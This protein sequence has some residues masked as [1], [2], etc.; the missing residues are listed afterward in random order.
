MATRILTDQA[1]RRTAP[2]P[3]EVRRYKW[4]YWAVH[5]AAGD[6]VCVTLYRR[7]AA[8]VVRR[9]DAK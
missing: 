1:I 7:G 2:T 9:L 3:Y 5:D 8:E 4:R 6:L